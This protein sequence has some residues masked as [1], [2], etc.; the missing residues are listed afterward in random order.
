M[1]DHQEKSLKIPEDDLEELYEFAPCGYISTLPDGR[2]VRVNETFVRQIGRP[3]EELLSGVK[4]QELMSMAGRVFYDTHFAPLIRLQGFVKEIACDLLRKDAGKLP[5]LVN[6]LQVTDS[7][8]EPKSIRFTVFDATERRRYEA[9]LLAA[10]R[11]SDH[12][13]TIVQASSDS[14]L[15]FDGS[16]KIKTWNAGAAEPAV[17]R[18]ELKSPFLLGVLAPWRFNPFGA[19]P[20]G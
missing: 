14:I 11:R 5:V 9:D 17:F 2:I 10:R 12:F 3:R 1:N 19:A 13:K 20:P 16:G 18:P 4:F 8:G 6:A 7:S 15:S